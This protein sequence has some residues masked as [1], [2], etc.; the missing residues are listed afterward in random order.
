MIE[1]FKPNLTPKEILYLG[2]FG[3]AYFGRRELEGDYDYQSLFKETLE[4]VSPHLFLGS[5][6]K[7]KMN[8]F[9]V[10][11]GMGYDYWKEKGWMHDDDPYGWFEWYVKYYNGRRHSD[12]DRQIHRWK[13]VCGVNGRWRNRIYNR[14]LETND[15]N[16]S[17]RI[18]QTL[19]HWG[20]KVNEI[21]YELYKTINK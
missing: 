19:L 7:P 20:Y 6:Y 10:R 14:I 17:P 18:Q 8:R 21:D 4:G 11:S 9:K 1:T 5:K 13:G 2:A 16:I 15:W 12:D 3:G